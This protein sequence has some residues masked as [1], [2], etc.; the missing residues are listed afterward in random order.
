MDGSPELVKLAKESNI[1]LQSQVAERFNP[2]I[3]GIKG[4]DLKPM[5]IGNVSSGTVQSPRYRSECDS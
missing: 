2:A 4:L 3:S 5:F 1:K